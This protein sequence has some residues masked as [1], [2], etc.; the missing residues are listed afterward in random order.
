M[1]RLVRRYDIAP[2]KEND[3]RIWAGGPVEME[4][5]ERSGRERGQ[6][7]RVRPSCNPMPPKAR[8]RRCLAGPPAIG[9]QITSDIV[10]RRME[11]SGRDLLEASGKALALAAVLLPVAGATLRFIAFQ[12]G[13]PLSTSAYQL[14]WTA[15]VDQLAAT[16]LAGLFPSLFYV[17]VVVMAIL[18]FRVLDRLFPRRH[19]PHERSKRSRFLAAAAILAVALIGFLA[20]G[21]WPTGVVSLVA[22]GLVG[23]IVVRVSNVP[24][25]WRLRHTWPVVVTLLATAALTSGLT[26]YLGGVQVGDYTFKRDAASVASNGTYAQIAESADLLYLWD[27]RRAGYIV[28]ISKGLVVGLRTQPGAA[29]SAREQTLFD[30]LVRRK[31]L[32]IGFQPPC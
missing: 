15:P 17:A 3:R 7:R 14:A 16:G 25:P 13:G 4:D 29:K 9:R 28:G 21:D 8:T 11:R 12:T 27:C 10:G 19:L 30:L 22:G 31:S 1:G 24:Q 5:P 6:G 2:C 20:F 26:G 32:A 18:A 23:T